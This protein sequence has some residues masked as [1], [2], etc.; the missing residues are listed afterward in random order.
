MLVPEIEIRIMTIKSIIVPVGN[1]V[2][3]NLYKIM[4]KKK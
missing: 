4:N 1:A 3:Y 2:I